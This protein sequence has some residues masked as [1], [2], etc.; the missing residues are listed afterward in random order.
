[1]R[2]TA[3]TGGLVCL[4]ANIQRVLLAEAKSPLTKTRREG[5]PERRTRRGSRGTPKE[6]HG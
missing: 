1:M 4:K 6:F 3:E 5:I 2:H